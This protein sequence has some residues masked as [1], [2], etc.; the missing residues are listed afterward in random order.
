V[1]LGKNLKYCPDKVAVDTVT[2][3]DPVTVLPSAIAA[4]IDKAAFVTKEEGI[5][6]AE[7]TPPRENTVPLGKLPKACADEIASDTVTTPEPVT[8][9]PS[10]IAAVIDKAAF[11]TKEVGIA[12]AEATPP[13]EN[14]VP[15]GKLPKACADNIASDTVTIP[16]PVTV[17]P[18][19]IAAVIDKAAFVT[20]E[21]GI[22]VAEATP[23][24]ENTVPLGKPPKACAD[25][26]ASDTV[27]TP[28]PVTVL[29]VAIAAVIDKAAFVTKE[30]GIAVV[31]ATPPRENTVPLGKLPK[32][33][34]DN[35][36]SDTVTAPDPVTVLPVATAAVID[37]AAFVTK[38][39]GIA[40]AEATPPRENTVPLGKLPKAC[41]D[42]IASDTVTA[43]DPVTVL[44]VAT[45]A[46]IDKAA[47]VTKVVGIAVADATPPRENTVPLGKLPKACADNIASDTVT[48]PEPVTVLSVATAAVIDKASFV[49]KELGIAVAEATPPRENTVP[50]GSPPKACADNI[51]SDTVTTPEPV[52][53]L[54]VAIAAI[55]DKAAFVTKEVGIAVA[56]A[57]PPRENTVPL[58]KLPKACADNIASD[59]VTTPEPV[60]VLPVATAA[61]IDKAAFVTKEEGIATAEA[62]PPRENTVPLGKLPKACADNIAS[63]TVTA[64]DPVTVLPVATAAVIDKAA[65]VTKEEGIATAEATP[66]RENTVPLGKPPKYCVDEMA[67]DT[68]TTPEPV[69]VLP[70]ATA[71]V[72]DKASFV[73]KVEGIALVEATPPRENTVTLFGKP[74][75]SCVDNIASDTITVL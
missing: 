67:S 55:I 32:A 7:A 30:E 74:P 38:V 23:P 52:T 34:A 44:L 16:D 49:T 18:V 15:L 21:E 47:F 3:P 60:T 33:C 46:V 10:A 12:V 50:L 59:T 54:P 57:T 37:K 1:P 62:T 24:R 14:T 65:F 17:L 20:K 70:V 56:E 71:A 68:V 31:E 22:A 53:V 51:A 64:P 9:L 27:T 6:V 39:V 58:G 36:A 42:E 28:E 13:R 40:V 11:V 2:T 5:A 29:P 41:V 4:V 26:I 35:I 48:T 72:I 19:A 75:K 66:P 25:N 43:P 63:D 73:T 69:T 61:V 8:I 45:A